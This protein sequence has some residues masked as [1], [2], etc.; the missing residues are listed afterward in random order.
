VCY[1]SR[2]P[3]HHHPPHNPAP[4]PFTLLPTPFITPH[5]PPQHFYPNESINPYGSQ[6][7]PS[8]CPIKAYH[9]GRIYRSIRTDTLRKPQHMGETESVNHNIW[10]FAGITYHASTIE[11]IAYVPLP[12]MVTQNL[13][14]T[15]RSLF[16]RVLYRPE[17]EARISDPERF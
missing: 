13:A 10:C 9:F 11:F 15:S 14:T 17:F 12:A 1:I 16:G 2:F 3:F 7:P 4:Y 6:Y 5:S 8:R